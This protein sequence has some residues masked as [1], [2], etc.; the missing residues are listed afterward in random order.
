MIYIF[1][2]DI[3]LDIDWFFPKL[4]TL[5]ILISYYYNSTFL[6]LISYII[7]VLKSIIYIHIFLKYFTIL[8]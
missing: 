7:R 6:V 2:A 1:I 3:K 8:S 5:K 4:L